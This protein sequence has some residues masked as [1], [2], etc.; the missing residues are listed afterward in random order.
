VTDSHNPY[1][2]V[3]ELLRDPDASRSLVRVERR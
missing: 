1:G 2:R 3:W